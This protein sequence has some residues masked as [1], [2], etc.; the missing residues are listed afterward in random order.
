MEGSG[1]TTILEEVYGTNTVRHMIMGKAVQRAFRGTFYANK[2]VPCPYD[3]FRVANE[4]PEIEMVV[5][6]AEVMGR[7]T[8]LHK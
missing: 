7:Y 1:L 5:E 4:N 6:E 3:S 2:Q 8:N